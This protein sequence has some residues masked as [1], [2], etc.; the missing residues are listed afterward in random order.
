M[1]RIQKEIQRKLQIERQLLSVQ[2]QSGH[3]QEISSSASPIETQLHGKLQVKL[4]SIER[5]LHQLEKGT[6]G[7]CQSC[8]EEID[9]ARLE[10]LPYAEQCI[11]CQRRLER[12]AIHGYAYAYPTH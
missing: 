11:D 6:Y 8:S 1:S 10:A 9:R 12:R 7:R 3:D 4:S 5:A 2:L